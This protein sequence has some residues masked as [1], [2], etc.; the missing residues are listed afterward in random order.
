M[1]S[2][3]FLQS[4]SDKIGS[5]CSDELD[6]LNVRAGGT[7]VLHP[8]LMSLIARA[9]AFTSDSL[10]RLRPRPIKARPA[11]QASTRHRPD[12]VSVEHPALGCQIHPYRI[13]VPGFRCTETPTKDLNW[14]IDHKG[15]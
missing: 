9:S 6:C 11:T 2:D 5:P 13:V 12:N 15:W 4:R 1:T 10:V 3:C 8:V 7:L 14:G